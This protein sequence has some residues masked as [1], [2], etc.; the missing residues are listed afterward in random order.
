M[1]Q[2]VPNALQ[3]KCEGS[4]SQHKK[5]VVKHSW[6]L[7]E[8][9]VMAMFQSSEADMHPQTLCSS[10]LEVPCNRSATAATCSAE[11]CCSALLIPAIGSITLHL[12]MLQVI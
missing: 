1:Q 6:P 2:Q 8:A 7:P 10:C 12:A 9:A 3:Y 5:L 4:I 11:R